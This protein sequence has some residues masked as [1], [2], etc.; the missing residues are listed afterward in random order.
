MLKISETPET[1]IKLHSVVVII[2]FKRVS[3][4]PYMIIALGRLVLESQNGS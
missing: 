2:G 3:L 4:E 1:Q